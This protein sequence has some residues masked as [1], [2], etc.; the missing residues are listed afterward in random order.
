M[1]SDADLV[2]KMN[3]LR[4]TSYSRGKWYKAFKMDAER[5]NLFTELD[6]E[7][8]MNMRQRLGPGVRTPHP[9]SPVSDFAVFRKGQSRTGTQY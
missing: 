6:E 5:E 9:P 1:T 4:S 8:H 2:R 7:K 3:A